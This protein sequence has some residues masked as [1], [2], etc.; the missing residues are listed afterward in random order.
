MSLHGMDLAWVL[1]L[2]NQNYR[3]L[4][5]I[6]S[7]ESEPIAPDLRGPCQ[8]LRDQLRTLVDPYIHILLA[9]SSTYDDNVKHIA[10]DKFA[11]RLTGVPNAGPFRHCNINPH[12]HFRLDDIVR[13][14]LRED[15][16]ETLPLKSEANYGLP[17]WLR[18]GG[19]YH[20]SQTSQHTYDSDNLPQQQP[21]VFGWLSIEAND[22]FT[23]Y[24]PADLDAAKNFLQKLNELGTN[25]LRHNVL[26]KMAKGATLVPPPGNCTYCHLVCRINIDVAI[27]RVKVACGMISAEDLV[28]KLEYLPD[29]FERAW[30]ELRSAEIRAARQYARVPAHATAEEKIHT[31]L[32]HLRQHVPHQQPQR[33]LVRPPRP[34]DRDEN[35]PP[36]P[37]QQR[38]PPHYWCPRRPLADIT[39]IEPNVRQAVR[40][41]LLRAPPRLLDGSRRNYEPSLNLQGRPL[42][43]LR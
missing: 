30:H 13:R 16:L 5:M 43:V 27:T 40:L 1:D 7:T 12:R 23:A 34:R 6:F 10:W 36:P 25:T 3:L 41:R 24:Q 2:V 35:P 28:N 33:P 14:L 8:Q 15:V 11:Y 22:N 18:Q 42:Q 29:E 38:R 21:S 37:Q 32:C 26:E 9:P 31:I 20:S 17:G 4:D 19:P 39:N